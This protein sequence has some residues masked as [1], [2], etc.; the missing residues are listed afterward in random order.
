M[1]LEECI[2]SILVFRYLNSVKLKMEA[3]FVLKHQNK[4]IVLYGVKIWKT[5]ISSAINVE[6][7]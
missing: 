7:L 5:V 2:A 3:Y 6:N 1:V 4:P